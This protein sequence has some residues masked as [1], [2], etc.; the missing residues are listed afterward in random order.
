MNTPIW[1]WVT[2][3]LSS[4]WPRLR[5]SFTFDSKVIGGITTPPSAPRLSIRVADSTTPQLPQADQRGIIQLTQSTR[6][7]FQLAYNLPAGCTNTPRLRAYG[8]FVP[9]TGNNNPIKTVELA[10]APLSTTPIGTL[11]VSQDLGT[12]QNGTWTFAALA[13]CT[14]TGQIF[15]R[16]AYLAT[17]P[18][19]NVNIQATT[20]APLITQAPQNASA[21][22]GSPASFSVTATGTDLAYQWQRSNNGGLA[23]TNIDQRH[24]SQRQHHRQLGR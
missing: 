23:Y 13:Y 8:V 12:S 22:E 17:G 19:I 18:V 9:R 4:I 11:N 2:L 21:T 20:A 5:N 16:Y 3:P 1:L 15:P 14:N 7:D 24:R 6:L 10:N